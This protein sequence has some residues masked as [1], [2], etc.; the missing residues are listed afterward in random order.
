MLN[1]EVA[2]R[3]LNRYE[4]AEVETKEALGEMIIETANAEIMH[5]VN[6]WL[7]IFSKQ[8]NSNVYKH[9]VE[10]ATTIESSSLK[11]TGS[12]NEP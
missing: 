4:S 1:P 11:E 2:Q 5:T 9:L 10:L 7:D 8:P 12:H 6:M 3:S